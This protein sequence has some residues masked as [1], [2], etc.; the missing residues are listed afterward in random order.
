[1]KVVQLKSLGTYLPF[2]SEVNALTKAESKVLVYSRIQE[3]S[4]MYNQFDSDFNTYLTKLPSN[5]LKTNVQQLISR[6]CIFIGV[7]QLQ[8]V[9]NLGKA[10]INRDI[11]GGAVLESSEFEIN[12]TTGETPNMDRCIYGSYYLFVNGI[13]SLNFDEIKKDETLNNLIIQ[14]LTS[15]FIKL[16]KLDSSRINLLKSVISIFYYMFMFDMKYT[17]A[18]AITLSNIELENEE[19]LTNKSIEK[20]TKFRDILSAFIDFNFTYETPNKLISDIISKLKM[21]GFLRLTSRIDHTISSI[22]LANYNFD[23]ML[24][25]NINSKLQEEIE[26]MLISKYGSKVKFDSKLI[27]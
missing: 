5:L 3:N 8:F 27:S 2:D 18:L 4:D 1:M 16:L 17:S 20:Y 26:N 15:L 14:Y 12:T 25:F 23:I 7:S 10:V 9:G 19:E 21:S 6:K 13:I 11:F 22:V 24:P